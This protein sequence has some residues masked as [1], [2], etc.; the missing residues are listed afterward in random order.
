MENNKKTSQW[1][2]I[3]KPYT[4]KQSENFTLENKQKTLQWKT[5]RKPYN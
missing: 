2:T 3:R 4:G 1:K 5:I